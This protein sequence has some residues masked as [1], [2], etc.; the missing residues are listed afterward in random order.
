[1]TWIDAQ[2]YAK[3]QGGYLVSISSD[4]ENN[5]IAGLKPSN[6]GG[7]IGLHQTSFASEPD[8]GWVWDSGEVSTYRS[9]GPEDPNNGTTPLGSEDYAEFFPGSNLW[10]DAYGGFIPGYGNLFGFIVEYGSVAPP[11]IAVSSNKSTLGLGQTATLTFTLSES[12]SDFDFNDITVSGGTL[13]NL[14]RSGTSYTATF[15]PTANSTTNGVVSVASNKFS[16]AA[17]NSNIDGADANNTVTMSVNTQT[18]NPPIC[19][20]LGTL[21]QTTSGPVPVEDLQVN[22]RLSFYVEPTSSD[23]AKVKW[24][25]RQTFHPA[26]ADLIDYL[27]IKIS[28]NTLGPGQPF[29]DL[30]VS[31]DHAILFDGTLIHAKVLVNGTSVAQMTEWS[32]DVEYFHI[33]TENHELVY[34]NGVPAETFIDNVSRKQFDNYAEFEAMYPNV[35]MMTELDIPRVLFRRQL[36]TASVQRLNALEE[37]WV[38]RYAPTDAATELV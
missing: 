11:T 1:L 12:V 20:A 16:D 35:P 23:C 28:A 32:G 7:W 13:G 36:S 30:Y 29:K 24:V 26:M 25:G 34:A 2:A 33:E 4:A 9:W 19:F 38:A 21:I 14:T 22:D 8:G 17:G 31:P 27:P 15:T 3:A 10:N 6:V 37:V 5:F 18:S